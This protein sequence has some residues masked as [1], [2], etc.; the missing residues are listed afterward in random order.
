MGADGAAAA[1]VEVRL[2][3]GCVS[4]AAGAARLVPRFFE[5]GAVFLGGMLDE[6]VCE[7][8][9]IDGEGGRKE[10]GRRSRFSSPTRRARDKGAR[11]ANVTKERATSPCPSL[12]LCLSL[13]QSFHTLLGFFCHAAAWLAS[14]VALTTHCSP[15]SGT[16]TPPERTS[17][18]IGRRRSPSDASFS[19]TASQDK[20]TCGQPHSVSALV[21]MTFSAR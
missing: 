5:A 8:K 4:S 14:L 11:Q 21:C 13:P 20:R 7:W 18:S 9:R 10:G 1:R 16:T 15:R 2:A 19:A 6:S 17:H 12:F 3:E